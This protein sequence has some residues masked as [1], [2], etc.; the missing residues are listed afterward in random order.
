MTVESTLCRALN[1]RFIDARGL[2]T[3]AKLNMGIIG[4]YDETLHDQLLDEARRLYEELDEDRR[5]QL[6]V[7]K[8]ELDGIKIQRNSSRSGSIQSSN[9]DDSIS[10]SSS[11]RFSLW[12]K[13][14]SV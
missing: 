11:R 8:S 2:V 1:I 12:S 4:Y 5:V 6:G 3:E 9:G 10:S 13:R 7:L 14:R